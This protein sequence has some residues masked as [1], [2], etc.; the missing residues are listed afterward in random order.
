MDRPTPAAPAPGVPHPAVARAR[1]FLATH[2]GERIDL[3]RLAEIA[4]MSRW[5]LVRRFSVEVGVPPQA[6]H[7]GLRLEHARRLL[8]AGV[9]V[10]TAAY[11][12]GFADQSHLTRLF[13]ERFG[14]T[15]GLFQREAQ[16]APLR[17]VA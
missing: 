7:V 17:H 12:S 13:K 11:R 1:H 15:P 9:P 5:H 3:R 16:R 6:Y 4:G 8:L 10:S 14:T 2:L